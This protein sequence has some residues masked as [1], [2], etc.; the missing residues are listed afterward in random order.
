[1]Q[2]PPSPVS[3]YDVGAM[4]RAFLLLV[5]F[6]CAN[7][8]SNEL[9]PEAW[10]VPDYAGAGLHIDEPWTAVDFVHAATV[11]EQV[12]AGH[13]ERLPRYRGVKSGVVFAKLLEP[14]APDE[15]QPLAIRFGAH[16]ERAEAANQTSK[17]YVENAYAV[18]T[19]EWIEL[20]G[21]VLREATMLTSNS[22]A[23]IASFGSDD[24]KREVRLQGVAKMKIGYG[25]MLLGGLIVAGDTRVAAA[26]R[27]AMVKHVSAALPVLF[28][29]APRE[30]QAQIR[31]QAKSLVAKLPKG[32]VRDAVIEAQQ[33]L[34]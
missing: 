11:L 1:M 4:K 3:A 10:G 8:K 30:T 29:V 26:D 5:L 21:V 2:F 33:V 16:A 18:P 13:R 15:D 9:P 32:E 28:P 17:L 25:T 6:A 23:F 20:M 34:P 22:D 7:Q 19:R 24:P 14:L 27:V 31:E 12:S